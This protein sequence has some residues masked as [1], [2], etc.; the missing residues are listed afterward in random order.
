[1]Q[2]LVEM[3]T[4]AARAVEGRYAYLLRPSTGGALAWSQVVLLRKASQVAMKARRVPDSDFGWWVLDPTADVYIDALNT[5]LGLRVAAAH[6]KRLPRRRLV[7]RTGDPFGDYP[8]EEFGTGSQAGE[9]SLEIVFAALR[10]AEAL[11]RDA[12]N[13]GRRP[14]GRPSTRP[15]PPVSAIL[16]SGPAGDVPLLPLATGAAPPP[17]PSEPP[18]QVARDGSQTPPLFRSPDHMTLGDC[19]LP[20]GKS[21][22]VL[23]CVEQGRLERKTE[24]GD[25]GQVV[26]EMVPGTPA[27]ELQVFELAPGLVSLGRGASLA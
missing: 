7:G 2:T 11:E 14:P 6:L 24:F 10:A 13:P 8:L 1:M 27:T 15:A 23:G 21:W 9:P 20:P 17:P 12:E 26:R 16:A 22:V 5:H 19:M 3:E 25:R 4:E 18:E